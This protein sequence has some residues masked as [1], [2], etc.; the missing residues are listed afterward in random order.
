MSIVMLIG[1]DDQWD[2]KLPHIM[3]SIRA[4]P[5][6]NTVENNSF[7]ILVRE[8]ILPEELV[9]GLLEFRKGYILVQS[10]NVQMVHIKLSKNQPQVR[11]RETG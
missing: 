9:S 4:M 6:N 5:S 7:P 8:L 1:G 2:L 10:R 3:L 11:T